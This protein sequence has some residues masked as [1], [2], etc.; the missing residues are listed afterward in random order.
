MEQ[1]ETLGLGKRLLLPQAL[2]LSPTKPPHPAAPAAGGPR[3]SRLSPCLRWPAIPSRPATVGLEPPTQG[4][5][6]LPCARGRTCQDRDFSLVVPR[7][8][9]P[10]GAAPTCR[11]EMRPAL[12]S[13]GLPQAAETAHYTRPIMAPQLN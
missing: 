7:T 6:I 2:T 1:R 3:S 11:G 4:S 5:C 12:A 13:M 10:P 8:T 9:V